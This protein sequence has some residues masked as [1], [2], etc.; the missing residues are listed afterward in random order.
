MMPRQIA[1]A[2]VEGVLSEQG[3]QTYIA[4]QLAYA[5]VELD[6]AEA[7]NGQGSDIDA[8][9]ALGRA[10]AARGAAAIVTAAISQARDAGVAAD[11]GVAWPDYVASEITRAV[12]AAVLEPSHEDYDRA[13]ALVRA[14][15][16]AIRDQVRE[17][18]AARD[19]RTLSPRVRPEVKRAHEL[20]DAYLTTAREW[21]RLGDVLY[22]QEHGA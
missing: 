15:A 5:R 3:A 21:E 7:L 1:Q 4:G 20:A 16:L 18:R 14:Q 11:A 6:T 2:R 17:Q 12:Q 8:R 10:S 19:G 9:D 13:A 22:E